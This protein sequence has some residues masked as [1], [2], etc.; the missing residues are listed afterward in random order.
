MASDDH[1]VLNEMKIRIDRIEQLVA[2]LKV[3]GREIPAVQKTCQS[4]L[5]MTYTLKFGISDVAEVY[6]T[7]GGM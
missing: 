7:Q 2:E 1:M 4:I 5:S 6:D 3:F